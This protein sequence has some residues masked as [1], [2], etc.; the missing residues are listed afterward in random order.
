MTK[1]DAYR[2]VVAG[3]MNDEVI[4]KF[5]ELIESYEKETLKRRETAN[6]KREEKLAGEQE[7]VDRIDEMLSEEPLTASDIAEVLGIKIQKATVL[8]KRTSATQVEVKKN[9]RKVKGYV[10]G[11]F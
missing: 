1:I 5:E 2:A 4:A 10:R 3:E 7:L 9:G 8:A 6:K 11:E